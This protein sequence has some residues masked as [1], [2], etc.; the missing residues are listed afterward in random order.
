[1]T[2]LYTRSTIKK[3]VKAHQP[4]SQLAKNVD[5]MLYLDYAL[6]LNRLAA[7]A[8]IMTLNDNERVVEARHVNTALEKVLQQFKG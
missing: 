6:F 4:K 3:I 8:D 2:R 5:V 7:E 1:M